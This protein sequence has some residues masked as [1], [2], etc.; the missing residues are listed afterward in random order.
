MLAVGKEENQLPIKM[1][2]TIRA[3]KSLLM[4][5]GVNVHKTLL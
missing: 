4:E 2:N 1:G 3:L 5:G